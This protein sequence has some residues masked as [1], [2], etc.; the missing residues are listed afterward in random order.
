LAA[1]EFRRLTLSADMEP[2]SGA[3][4][5]RNDSRLKQRNGGPPVSAPRTN[6]EKQKKK[7]FTPLV[8]VGLAVAF[9]IVMV[10]LYLG[11]AFD[12]AK[13][14]NIGEDDTQ[15][16]AP[17]AAEEAGAAQ[18]SP[19]ATSNASDTSGDTPAGE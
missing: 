13:G 2:R 4:V 10:L 16:T 19:Q 8:G 7:H 9:G 3:D 12:R 18:E 6:I 17:P 14:P 1:A 15:V 5:Y 11:N